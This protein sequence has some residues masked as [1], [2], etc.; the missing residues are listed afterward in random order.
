M[1][2]DMEQKASPGLMV[3][4]V[5]VKLERKEVFP[6]LGDQDTKIQFVSYFITTVNY[7]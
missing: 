1:A 5:F 4:N 2:L 6:K 3:R 7:L